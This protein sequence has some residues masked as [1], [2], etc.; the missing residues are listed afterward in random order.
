V[1]YRF[2][3]GVGSS[4]TATARVGIFRTAS[5][6][7]WRA[8]FCIT[9]IGEEYWGKG[10]ATASVR[11]II[12]Y[13]FSELGLEEICAYVFHENKAPIRVLEKSGMNQ[14]E[15]VNEYHCVSG[16]YRTS[17]NY[18]IRRCKKNHHI[19]MFHNQT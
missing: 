7:N 18:M 9:L 14:I 13:G 19:D 5:R 12:S 8:A 16:M 17:L 4:S 6:V 3:I 15:E 1:S 10:I 11:L 2:L